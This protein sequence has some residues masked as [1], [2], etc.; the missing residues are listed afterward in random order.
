MGIIKNTL[1]MSDERR[2]KKL[3]TKKK[4]V[5]DGVFNAELNAFLTRILG[6]Y[7]YAGLEVR[8]S[9]VSTEIRIKSAGHE[10]LL[11][12][13]ALR[14]REI[15]SLIEKR[16]NFNDGDNKVDMTILPV[17][18][19]ALCAAANVE[20]LKMKLLNGIPVRRAVNNVMGGVMRRN[21]VGCT[22]I[23]AGKVRGQRAKTAKYTQGYLISTGQPVKEFVDTAMRHV[24]MRQGAI[25]IKVAI[26][27]SV[28]KKVGRDQIKVMPDFIK[29]HE[30]KDE[31]L[32]TGPS[33][34]FPNK[35]EN[36][37]QRAA[38]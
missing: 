15:K 25:G 12:K 35:P 24:P 2:V 27:G 34:H 21:A 20:N 36:A 6:I 37:E 31:K 38:I 14:V 13:G 23:V 1:K 19:R 30:P 22:V 8:A 18:D 16:Y 17:G 32:P 7:G 3:N 5:A 29:I 33:V 10:D 9:S 11:D 26:M 4:F 28:E